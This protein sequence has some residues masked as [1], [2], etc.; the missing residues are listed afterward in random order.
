MKRDYKPRRRE[1]IYNEHLQQIAEKKFTIREIDIIAC[2]LHNRGEKKI[3]YFLGISYRT[4]GTHV[5][6]IL[7]KLEY[8]SRDHIIDAVE[9]SGK[10]RYIREYYLQLV[11]E[12]TF[13]KYLQKI[14]TSINCA[15]IVC[16]TDFGE[17]T[18]DEERLLFQ[19]EQDLKLANLVLKHNMTSNDRTKKEYNLYF[20]KEKFV[21]SA[22]VD[23]NALN[24]QDKNIGLLL[25][26]NIIIPPSGRVIDFRE[27]QCY[28]SSVLNLLQEVISASEIKKTIQEFKNQIQIIIQDSIVE[29]KIELFDVSTYKLKPRIIVITVFSIILL[30]GIF[31]QYNGLILPRTKVDL[32][33]AQQDSL[34]LKDSIHL[35][36]K[37][38]QNLSVSNLSREESEKNYKVIKQ[39]DSV[40]EQIDLGQ[41]QKYFNSDVLQSS[42]LVNCLYN[43]N[44]I[45]SYLLVEKH[46]VQKAEKILR[47]TKNL[48]ENYVS[49]VVD[50]KGDQTKVQIDFDK[51]TPAEIYT[52]LAM[53]KDLPEMYTITLYFLGR[54]LIYQRNLGKLEEAEKYFVLSSYLG[55]KLGLFEEVLSIINGVMIIKGDNIDI[56]IENKNYE[57]AREVLKECIELVKT[58]KEDNREYQ[59]NYKPYNKNPTFIIPKKNTYHILDCTKRLVKLYTK[60]VTMVDDEGELK[61]SLEEISQQ[62]I[63]SNTSAG[64]L[65]ILLKSSDKPNRIVADI[66]NN[67][68]YFLLKLYDKNIGL[69]QF[70]ANL[71]S[72]LKLAN[73]DDIKIIYQI[74]DLAKSLSRS[75]E[76]SKAD[77]FDGLLKVCER[78]VRQPA[79]AEEEK[80]QLLKKIQDFKE[81]RDEINTKLKRV[82]A[83]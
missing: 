34:S 8:N 60:L 18:D 25:D 20:I 3:A 58:I 1:K 19:L 41:I 53:I 61:K 76:F 73:G 70:K 44:A 5:R 47:Y 45:S 69:T 7:S 51:L 63:G 81:A 80:K 11:V 17:V 72:Q 65:K 37:F 35:L 32:M 13:E 29:P 9:K 71:S 79:I 16:F 43:L 33:E 64:I 22:T 36:L 56:N 40:I 50:Y 30:S 83:N 38:S 77:S 21:T 26:K 75:A 57:Q 12:S 59:V 74:F 42:E 31:L 14:R 10:M 66:Y 4:V 2:I 28:Y 62:F 67:L 78:L 49:L 46:D 55:N 82:V 23:I 6:N 24:D 68:G 39:F 54:S 27:D 52:E 48:A 15:Q